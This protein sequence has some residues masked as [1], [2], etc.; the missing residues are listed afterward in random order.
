MVKRIVTFNYQPKTMTLFKGHKLAKI[1]NMANVCSCTPVSK[2]EQGVRKETE[3]VNFQPR[4]VL[5]QFC[6]EFKFKINPEL[7]P[8]E[9]YQLLQLLFENKDVFA[10]SLYKVTTYPGYELLNY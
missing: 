7:K 3:T 10:R 9:R 6:T 5:D 4:E 8:E 1:E 2:G